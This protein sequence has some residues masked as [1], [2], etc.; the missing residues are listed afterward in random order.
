MRVVKTIVA[1]LIA[2]AVIPTIAQ[3]QATIAGVVK[4]SSGAVLPGVTVEAASPALI[5]KVRSVVTDGTGQYQIV[6]LRPGT[7]S[8]T[9]GL[10]GFNTVKREGIELLGNFTATVNAELRVGGVAETLTVTGTS[11]IV[12]VQTVTQ[13]RVISKD[14]LDAIPAG[15]STSNFSILVPGA[16]GASDVGGSN[17]LNLVTLAVHGG[18]TTDQRVEI[19]GLSIGNASGSGETSNFMPDIT[20]AQEIAVNTAAGTADQQFAGVLINVVPREGGNVLHGSIFGGGANSSL[21]G[22]NYSQALQNEGLK[23]PNTI[24]RIFDINPGVGGPILQDKLWF[25]TTAR[26]QSTQTFLAGLWNNLNAGN[27]NAWSYA[28][29]YNHPAVTPIGQTSW[30]VRLTSQATPRNKLGFYFEPQ[31]RTWDQFGATS[32][33]ESAIHYAFPQNHILQASWSVPVN[34]RL[35]IDTKVSDAVQGYT[36]IHPPDGSVWQSLIPVTEQGGLIPGLVYRGQGYLVSTQPFQTLTGWIG[37]AQS[38]V[39]YVTGSHAMKVGF[40]DSFGERDTAFGGNT[41]DVT[42]RFNNG[43]PNQIT[44]YATPYTVHNHMKAE[45]GV[46]AQDKWTIKRLTLNV[47][48]RFDY[49]NVDFPQQSLG[50]GLLVPNRSITFPETDFVSFKD[51]S[52]RLGAA[53]DLFANGKTALKANFGK[54]VLA[55]RLSTDYTTLGNPVNQLSNIVTRSWTDTTPVGSALYYV[56][57]CNLLNPLANGQCGAMSNV[58]FGT[59]TAAYTFD[60]KTLNGWNVRPNDY[61]F[62]VGVQHQLLPRV[63]VNFGYFRRWYNNFT[64]TDNLATAPTDY[65]PF[66]ITAPVDSRLPGGGGYVLGGLYNLNPNR[67]G[68]VNNYY[69]LASELGN[70]IEHWNGIDATINVRISGNALLQGGLSSGYTLT[71]DCNIVDKYLGSVTLANSLGTVQSTQMC[72]LE[73]PWLTQVKLIGSYTVPK[74]NVQ[75]SAAFQSTPGPAISANYVATNAVVQPSL[76]RPLSGGAANVTVNLVAPGSLYGERANQ[77][78]LRFSKLLKFGQGKFRTAVNLDVYN[79]LNANPVLTVNNNYAAWQVPT[80]ILLARFFKIGAQ[81]DF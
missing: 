10:A 36:D 16:T 22:S 45:L 15:R 81:F 4:D 67:V 72:R 41:S 18:R 70:Y 42:Y 74:I 21:Q 24:K 73:T 54:Y 80:G 46:Y 63:G 27:P 19:D 48:G 76:G 2:V 50:P 31:V 25:F 56:P 30:S 12:D 1:T 53:Y 52:P 79:S 65:S 6:D 47:G 78:D 55:Q 43:V 7:Y 60:P 29:D 51:L 62:S 40:I 59:A 14:V 58:N 68:Q 71:D 28:P 39:S 49:F 8:V 44:E 26:F 34:S 75:T 5:E 38:S 77:L 9:F 20:G 3:A 35:L 33:P 64:A 13:Q 17:N 32:S 57:Q 37:I 23:S 69:T 61:E 11:P 66:S